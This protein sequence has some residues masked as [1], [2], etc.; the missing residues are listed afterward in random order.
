MSAGCTACTQCDEVPASF[1]LFKEVGRAS[2]DALLQWG[3]SSHIA[4]ALELVQRG[5]RPEERRAG[6]VAI[7]VT[8]GGQMRDENFR[9]TL[10]T[11]MR[12]AKILLVENAQ[13]YCSYADP[14]PLSA[15][16][17]NPWVLIPAFAK[18]SLVGW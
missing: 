5:V 7:G 3:S 9:E 4:I 2:I 12:R 14:P 11:K 1:K 17:T 10:P 18:Y 16:W 15:H 13:S 6:G 8:Q